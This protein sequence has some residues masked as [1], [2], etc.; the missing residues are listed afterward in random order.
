MAAAGFPQAVVP[1]L[2]SDERE[3]SKMLFYFTIVYKQ[4]FGRAA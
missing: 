1:R 3:S 4:P 2:I